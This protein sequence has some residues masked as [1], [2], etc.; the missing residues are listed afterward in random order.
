MLRFVSILCAMGLMLV[1]PAALANGSGDCNGDGVVNG[2]D[3]EIVRGAL[4]T[5]D[6]DDGFVAEAD[7]DGDGT[8]SLVDLNNVLNASK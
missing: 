8:I 1:A 2:D 4:N 5:T 7:T 3:I 6:G